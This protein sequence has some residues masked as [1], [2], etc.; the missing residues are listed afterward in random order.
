MFTRNT[1]PR[2]LDTLAFKNAGAYNNKAMRYWIIILLITFFAVY[3][4]TLADSTAPILTFPAEI[5]IRVNGFEEGLSN[6][7]SG[8]W[9]TLS[10]YLIRDRKKYSEIENIEFCETE[11]SYCILM[12]DTE[13]R[14]RVTKKDSFTLTREKV[15]A[16]LEDLKRRTDTPPIDAVFS[17]E[18]G[19]VT[20]FSLSRNGGSLNIEKSL[21][22][23][24][25]YAT[26]ENKPSTTIDLTY[27]VVYPKMKSEDTE[28]LGINSLIGEGKSNFKGSPKNRIY[29]I[30]VATSRYNGALIKPGEEFSFVS[31][32]G[33]VDGEHGYLPELVIKKDKT[34]PE[35]GG[36][37]C[38]VS[39]TAFR[40]A[41]YSGLKIT[42]R[43]NHAYPVRYYNP[44]GMDAT[45]YVPR[46]DLRFINNTPGHILI[47]T[48]IEGTELTFQ[49]YGTG[50]G[51]KVEVDG[52]KITQKNP[53]GSMKATFTQ[54]VL[55][56]DNQEMINDVFNSAYDSP[57]KYP[58]PGEE[59]FTSKPD[60]WSKKQW[61]D[62]KKLHNL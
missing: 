16:Y 61:Q 40:A 47:Q 38:Q 25:N 32:L 20:T 12:N 62:Y 55:D 33:E 10:P 1:Q 13:E 5:K 15:A 24:A 9:I 44:Q 29:N 57:N 37:I 6:D 28:N 45:V 52:P 21:K 22:T 34:E 54:K 41:I 56:K 39:T 2:D 30:R 8:Q 27:D 3:E 18:D 46:P 42:A 23:I 26:I 43:R 36:G 51:R 14:L 17:V 53:D 31:L 48:K 7:T 50:D 58:H 35:F 49:F 19:K 60:D 59:K 4:T 11:K